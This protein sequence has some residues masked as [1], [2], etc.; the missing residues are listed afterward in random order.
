MKKVVIIFIAC[1]LSSNCFALDYSAYLKLAEKS[2]NANRAVVN[3]HLDAIATS[4]V[5]YERMLSQ[6]YGK[7]LICMPNNMKLSPL[8]IEE[9]IDKTV[10][11]FRKKDLSKF[12]VSE[13]AF[14][15][16]VTQYPCEKP[17]QGR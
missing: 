2:D 17:V 4:F 11:M 9:S 12:P 7:R 5:T 3:S 16:M 15:G 10:K 13:L 6:A 8:K 1:I 14:M